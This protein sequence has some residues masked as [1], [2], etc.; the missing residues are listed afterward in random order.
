MNE[1]KSKK[2]K[3]FLKRG[4]Q[5][6]DLLTFLWDKRRLAWWNGSNTGLRDAWILV[7]WLPRTNCGNLGEP[8]NFAEHQINISVKWGEKPQRLLL[9]SYEKVYVKFFWNVKLYKQI[10]VIMR[11]PLLN[12]LNI[13]SVFENMYVKGN[14][15]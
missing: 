2:T 1:E 3:V 10:R 5:G 4:L 9:R 6:D 13:Q 11:L 14:K 8:P 15:I 12:A 7:V